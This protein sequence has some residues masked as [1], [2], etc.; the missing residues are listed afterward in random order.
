MANALFKE[1]NMLTSESSETMRK[2]VLEHLGMRLTDGIDVVMSRIE[3][4]R[5]ST[6]KKLLSL[7]L[8]DDDW[9]IE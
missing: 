3:F 5:S 6:A 1:A 4:V 2:Q 7:P 8:H 9:P